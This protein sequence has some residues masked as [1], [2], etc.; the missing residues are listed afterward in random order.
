MK[1]IEKKKETKDDKKGKV[2]KEYKGISHIEVRPRFSVGKEKRLTQAI[3][4]R[5]L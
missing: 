1:L 5:G 2:R 3:I 4:I